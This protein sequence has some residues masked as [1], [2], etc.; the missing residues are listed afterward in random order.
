[1]V[2][3]DV[4][5]AQVDQC[6]RWAAAQIRAGYAKRT[7]TWHGHRDVSAKS[8]PGDTGYAKLPRIRTLTE[9]YVTNGLTTG[10]FFVTEDDKTIMR[11]IIRQELYGDDTAHNKGM[12]PI[13]R[14]EVKAIVEQELQRSG[15]VTRVELRELAKLGANDAEADNPTPA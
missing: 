14:R 2:T 11:N 12:T 15:S 13:I 8:C 3:D 10:D 6:A 5:D 9:H 7:A 1:M 4:T